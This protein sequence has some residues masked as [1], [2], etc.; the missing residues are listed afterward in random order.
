MKIMLKPNIKNQKNQQKSKT[1]SPKNKKEINKK[2][3]K[4][5]AEKE[6]NKSIG[7]KTSK[8]VSQDLVSP[9]K[10]SSSSKIDVV[11]INKKE[12]KNQP[13]KKGWWSN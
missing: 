9:R 2:L 12:A 10:K 11:D 5:F 8:S 3:D 6:N 7:E 1:K 4:T 13:K